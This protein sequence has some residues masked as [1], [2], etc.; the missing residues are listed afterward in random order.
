M[1]L[2]TRS[3][4]DTVHRDRAGWTVAS[5]QYSPATER[6]RARMFTHRIT[7]QPLTA[8][9]RVGW[10]LPTSVRAVLDDLLRQLSCDVVRVTD[11]HHPA[12]RATF[13]CSRQVL[14]RR[15][16]TD[17]SAADR[18]LVLST[19]R[20]DRGSV[21]A[22]CRHVARFQEEAVRAD[23][24]SLRRSHL[25]DRG[26]LPPLALGELCSVAGS[27]IL[28]WV[29][30]ATSQ[31]RAQL[32]AAPTAESRTSSQSTQPFFEPTVGG[33]SALANGQGVDVVTKRTRWGSLATGRLP[34]SR[35][36]LFS[37]RW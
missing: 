19:S 6:V 3:R 33:H 28:A 20:F 13:A 23:A 8:T 37:A 15:R 26:E 10:D 35:R 31:A 34:L 11:D 18:A 17:A 29:R 22:V 25:A 32:P 2:E 24:R 9:F 30:P 16:R 5:T 21:R 7:Y 12:T 1:R 4:R 14:I 27:S 36:D